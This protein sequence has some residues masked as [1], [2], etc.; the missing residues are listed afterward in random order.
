VFKVVVASRNVSFH[1]YNLKS[2]ACDQYKKKFNLWGRGGPNWIAECR[3]FLLEEDSQWTM[4]HHRKHSMKLSYHDVTRQGYRLTG[5]NRV[6]LGNRSSRFMLLRN[7]LSQLQLD[8]QKD[9]PLHERSSVFDRL[10]WPNLIHQ[11]NV[12]QNSR[13]DVRE[14]A[15]LAPGSMPSK[16]SRDG[17]QIQ[18]LKGKKPIINSEGP[19]SSLVPICGKCTRALFASRSCKD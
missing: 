14:M 4:V 19:I 7:R 9:L 8:H 3:K 18:I 15:N 10:E 12:H 1:I 11:P 6:P 16:N 5:A 13:M 17:T 2:F